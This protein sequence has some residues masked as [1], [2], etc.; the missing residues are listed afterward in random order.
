MDK[1]YDIEIDPEIIKRV[2]DGI[3][4][5]V[6]EMRKELELRKAKKANRSDRRKKHGKEDNHVRHERN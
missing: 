3:L 6:E 5:F 2:E 4:R 1:N